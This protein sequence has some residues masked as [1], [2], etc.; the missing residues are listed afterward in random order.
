MFGC[1]YVC[2]PI[3]IRLFLKG[4]W[5]FLTHLTFIE[6]LPTL[7]RAPPQHKHWSIYPFCKQFLW[8]IT[9]HA[10]AV[11]GEINLALIE[12]CQFLR[13]CDGC[14]LSFRINLCL[15]VPPPDSSIVARMSQNVTCC[16][17]IDLL[18]F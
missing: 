13:V 18:I 8:M 1:G 2:Q 6:T 14:D 7:G 3:D 16:S 4:S 5:F 15:D 9:S 12:I 11:D 10:A 17:Q